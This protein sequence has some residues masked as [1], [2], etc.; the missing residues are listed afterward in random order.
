MKRRPPWQGSNNPDFNREF[1]RETY[2]RKL[3]TSRG[4]IRENSSDIFQSYDKLH[5]SP[6]WSVRRKRFRE[7]ENVHSLNALDSDVTFFH[8]FFCRES[9]Q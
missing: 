1:I 3:V 2:F 6:D 8:N 4:G 9:L 5:R 7:K